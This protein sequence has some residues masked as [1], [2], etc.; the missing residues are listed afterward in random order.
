MGAMVTSMA[1]GSPFT[2]IDS[3]LHH[4]AVAG[5]TGPAVPAAFN[6]EFKL[7]RHFTRA[8]ST[9]TVDGQAITDTDG[10]HLISRQPVYFSGTDPA[11][12]TIVFAG[13]ATRADIELLYPEVVDNNDGLMRGGVYTYREYEAVLLDNQELIDIGNAVAN[14]ATG[15]LKQ[16]PARA[17]RVF[18][19]HHLQRFGQRPGVYDGKVRLP[20]TKAPY[21]FINANEASLEGMESYMNIVQNMEEG[22]YTGLLDPAYTQ[23]HV[24]LNAGDVLTAKQAEALARDK[25]AVH[26]KIEEEFGYEDNPAL[27]K[28]AGESVA[29]GLAHIPT[30][31]DLHLQFNLR[32]AALGNRA[33]LPTNTALATHIGS[34]NLPFESAGKR[35]RA[36]QYFWDKEGRAQNELLLEEMVLNHG[37]YGH[38]HAPPPAMVPTPDGRIIVPVTAIESVAKVTT[39]HGVVDKH[40]DGTT[41]VLPAEGAFSV[42]AATDDDRLVG[43]IICSWGVASRTVARRNT[44]T[45]Y[46][47]ERA[48]EFTKLMQPAS[49]PFKG[50]VRAIPVVVVRLPFAALQQSTHNSHADAALAYDRSFLAAKRAFERGIVYRGRV[51]NPTLHPTKQPCGDANSVASTTSSLKRAYDVMETSGRLTAAPA[52]KVARRMLHK[53]IMRGDARNYGPFLATVAASEHGMS[54]RLATQDEANFTAV[55][56]K[57]LNAAPFW[58][59]EDQETLVFCGKEDIDGGGRPQAMQGNINRSIANC[60]LL[61]Q[62][63]DVGQGLIGERR[64]KMPNKSAKTAVTKDVEALKRAKKYMMVGRPGGD[65]VYYNSAKSATS[66]VPVV[67]EAPDQSANGSSARMT[68]AGVWQEKA[69]DLENGTA[70]AVLTSSLGGAVLG[71]SSSKTA[72]GAWLDGD[73]HNFRQS[74]SSNNNQFYVVAAGSAFSGA[75]GF[76]VTESF[77]AFTPAGDGAAVVRVQR[78]ASGG[79]LAEITQSRHAEFSVGDIVYYAYPVDQET[80]GMQSATPDVVLAALS[81]DK[82]P[83]PL[84]HAFVAAKITEWGAAGQDYAILARRRARGLQSIA[85]MVHRDWMDP[86]PPRK[87]VIML[88]TGDGATRRTNFGK[89][90]VTTT[91]ENLSGTVYDRTSMPPNQFYER[92]SEARSER[93]GHAVDKL[94]QVRGERSNKAKNLRATDVAISID[95]RTVPGAVSDGRKYKRY[96][97]KLKK[98]NP[99]H[100]NAA[101]FAASR[102]ARALKPPAPASNVSA[103]AAASTTTTAPAAALAA[104]ANTTPVPTTPTPTALGPVAATPSRVATAATPAT[105]ATPTTPIMQMMRGATATLGEIRRCRLNVDRC[106]GLVARSKSEFLALA[107]QH[108]SGNDLACAR[109]NWEDAVTKKEVAVEEY[110]RVNGPYLARIAATVATTPLRA[111]DQ[112]ARKGVLPDDDEEGEDDG[113]ARQSSAPSAAIQQLQV[114]AAQ[115]TANLV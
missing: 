97:E 95:P 92:V 98:R 99:V 78:G 68:A 34:T 64:H 75:D 72:I 69:F 50:G 113:G 17:K 47:A 73:W 58:R 48:A 42:T 16:G 105:P 30:S 51:E 8:T 60:A 56:T 49:W 53:G 9:V 15:K 109:A 10:L 102:K 86:S 4:R 29:K 13:I 40:Y 110:D 79:A 14:G 37:R 80:A 81:G 65:P 108:A 96:L 32:Q 20:Y 23:D 52:Y 111:Q 31:S 12:A 22:R 74:G 45:V 24:T 71:T 115:A 94:P 28:A 21:Q 2:N 36:K 27:L 62:I 59:D 19:G 82:I 104:A 33:T 38:M 1:D 77:T 90:Q 43:G 7:D 5:S 84:S 107:H 3:S 93:K 44:A 41:V 106:A 91:G 39:A 114:A 57:A 100:I 103:A 18:A 85:E 83:L 89:T 88:R 87:I 6:A 25:F 46:T 63:R 26:A 76:K 54:S 61:S 70:G 66:V 67:F 11:A 101:V 35:E 112:L 55:S